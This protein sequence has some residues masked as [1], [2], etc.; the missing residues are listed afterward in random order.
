MNF[1][2]FNN[3]NKGIQNKQLQQRIIYL[4]KLKEK[5]VKEKR[6]KELQHQ[7]MLED[8]KREQ[9]SNNT[10]SK[11]ETK[12]IINIDNEIL[13]C[14]DERPAENEPRAEHEKYMN[15]LMALINKILNNDVNTYVYR[16]FI[17]SDSGQNDSDNVFLMID[18]GIKNNQ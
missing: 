2:M 12:N 9:I 3:N 1:N 4:E 11:I 13:E 8:K 14:A 15:K 6:F 10:P 17:T 16:E 7:K 18:E 5:L